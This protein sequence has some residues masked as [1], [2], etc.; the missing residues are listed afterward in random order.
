MDGT[1]ISLLVLC[2]LT[3]MVGSGLSKIN[4]LIDVSR[5]TIYHGL[6]GIAAKELEHCASNQLNKLAKKNHNMTFEKLLKEKFIP[7]WDGF[8][9][10]LDNEV[11]TLDPNSPEGALF[12]PLDVWEIVQSLV[13]QRNTVPSSRW[14]D[15]MGSEFEF[16]SFAEKYT[17]S[18]NGFIDLVQNLGG[19]WWRASDLKHTMEREEYILLSSDLHIQKVLLELGL[20]SVKKVVGDEIF[21]GSPNWT[22]TE[23]AMRVFVHKTHHEATPADLADEYLSRNGFATT[24]TNRFR[25]TGQENVHEYSFQ[26]CIFMQLF[27]HFPISD[28]TVR[29]SCYNLYKEVIICVVRERSFYLCHSIASCV[30]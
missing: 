24:V 25:G 21:L 27:Y 20:L 30:P 5:L 17:T 13:K 14:I 7:A 1:G 2:G 10:G 18:P 22:L 6:C 29:L 12:S 11:G 3:R 19:G 28:Q 16:T 8:R 26:G 4:N 15:T 9:F 23:K